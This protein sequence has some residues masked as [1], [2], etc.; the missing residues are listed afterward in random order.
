[1]PKG[2]ASVIARVAMGLLL[3]AGG[4][5]AATTNVFWA[6][7][8]TNAW[9]SAANWSPA[10]VPSIANE[11]HAQVFNGGTAEITQ[12]GQGAQMITLAYGPG[13][14]GFV[15]LLS[16][17]LQTASAQNLGRAGSAAFTQESGTTNL[18]GG[19]LTIG[20]QNGSRGLYRLNGG[21]LA[22]PAGDINV[23]YVGGATGMIEQ[24]GGILG[25][26]GSSKYLYIGRE[27]NAV[28]TYL[29]NGGTLLFTNS[30]YVAIGYLGK[31]H[32]I[33]SNGTVV[34]DQQFNIGKEGGSSGTYT[35]VNGSFLARW[36]V[37]GEKA[38]STGLVG[39]A[40]GT[41]LGGNK[42]SVGQYGC[43]TVRQSGG[44]VGVTNQYLYLGEAATGSGTYVLEGTGALLLTNAANYLY[45]GFAG[46]GTFIQSNGTVAVSNYVYVGKNSNAAGLYRIENGSLTVGQNLVLG[47]QAS[48]TGTLQIVGS[49]ATIAVRSYQQNTNSALDVLLDSG[50]ASTINVATMASLG[51]ELRVTG[52]VELGYNTVVTLIN[53]ASITG[54]FST[55]RFSGRN[56]FNADV[57]YDTV[58]GDVKLSHFRYPGKGFSVTVN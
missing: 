49:S 58:N 47:E 54:A 53:A 23:G 33:Q 26:I 1:M 45:V 52:N 42:I 15:R 27:A 24:A 28:G 41:F 16:G 2:L 13:E 39:V 11:S 29:M 51:G 7:T 21:M 44:T 31:G 12:P 10:V 46:T 48:A 38:G 3:A 8:G 25:S 40:G 43:G 55:V 9:E 32:F 4:A 57:I 20:E 34:A 17:T 18:C 35:M 56:L 14:S 37:V 5:M 6:V 50:G 30:N 36:P 19:T 22:V